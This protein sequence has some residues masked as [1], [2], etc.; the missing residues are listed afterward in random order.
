MKKIFLIL[1]IVSILVGSLVAV[2]RFAP[3]YLYDMA[4]HGR[5][6]S[7][8]YQLKKFNRKL[9]NPTQN[10]YVSD[11]SGSYSNLW[12]EFH[13]KD[14]VV[15]LPA[16]HPMY[17]A[18]PSIRLVPGMAD[19]Q[20][21]LRFNGP[22][23]REIA[24]LHLI[25]SGVWSHEA[26]GQ[27]LFRLPMVRREILKKTTEEIWEDVFKHKIMGWD[28]TWQEMV[29]N[30]YILHLRSVML[31]EHFTNFGMVDGKEMAYVE[32]PSS[33]KD[34]KTEMIFSFQK[35][36]LLSY[37]L[38]TDL[39]AS[40][41]KEIRARFING[42]NFR[43]SDPALTPIIYREFKQLNFTQQTDQEGML[44]L[45]SAWSHDMNNTEMLKEMI[46]YL[47]RGSKNKDQLKALYRFAYSRY[48]KTFTTRDTGLD[49]D[50]PDIRLSRQIEL[51]ELTERKALQERPRNIMK[52]AELSSKERMDQMLK[53]AKETKPEKKK[54]RQKMII[55]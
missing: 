9:F 53:K 16:G 18:V 26:N 39:R 7:H 5:S 40:D 14:V 33:N 10:T 38:V 47:E 4:I 1:M 41:S 8:W 3:A 51:E 2:V 44:F 11:I 35:G 48:S 55:Y 21:G 17:Q 50:D 32:I 52:A 43:G 49:D 22:S 42:I 54:S 31:P 30:L 15:P 46:Y 27:E 37:L 45:L 23:G 6:K 25:S 36:L 28:L 13:V 19:P 12:R 34:Y 24:R 20:L 29:Y